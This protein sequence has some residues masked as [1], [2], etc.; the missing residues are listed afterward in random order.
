MTTEVTDTFGDLADGIAYYA[1]HDYSDE[2]P[3]IP[4]D[5]FPDEFTEDSDDLF[6]K[7][8]QSAVGDG[9][10][11]EI[12]AAGLGYVDTDPDPSPKPSAAR[13]RRYWTRGAG[14]A[15]IGWG[16]PGDWRRCVRNLRKHVGAGA[17]GLCNVYHRS[18]VGAPPGKGHKS[19]LVADVETKGLFVENGTMRL[20]NLF[21][22][23]KQFVGWERVESK[24]GNTYDVG[25]NVLT[26]SWEAHDS[27]NFNDVVAVGDEEVE[28]YSALNEFE[29]Q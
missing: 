24:A 5:P 22:S 18:A 16:T 10:I 29:D 19:D 3:G 27:E 20:D 21:L 14:A 28:V 13:L 8:L 23:Q 4:D 15:K 11:L 25:Y 17:E 9:S 26:K 7:S 2:F 12:K 6:E 1:S